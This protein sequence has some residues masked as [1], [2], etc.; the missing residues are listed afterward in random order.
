MCCSCIQNIV[1]KPVIHFT[2]TLSYKAYS[3]TCCLSIYKQ[4][5]A[6]IILEDN[7]HFSYFDYFCLYQIRHYF[8]YC[9]KKTSSETKFDIFLSFPIWEKIDYMF[10]EYLN[11]LHDLQQFKP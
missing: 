5:E 11:T 1:Y 8:M 2:K 6:A 9:Q 3:R 10:I 4:G 7:Y